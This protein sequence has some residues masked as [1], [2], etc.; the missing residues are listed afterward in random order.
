MR[1]H[2]FV[3]LLRFS[4]NSGA[5]GQHMAGHQEWIKRGTDDGVFLLVGSIQPGPGGAV[6]AHGTSRE[7]LRKRVDA[8]PFVAEGVVTAEIIE[9]A[10][11]T[12][13]ERLGFLL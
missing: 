13:D 7:E 2:M 6:I 8:D 1:E 11:G 10:P 9:I 3:V 4:D 12:V 5:A